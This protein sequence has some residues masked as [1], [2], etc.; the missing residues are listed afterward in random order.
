MACTV[1]DAAILLGALAGA[2]PRDPA[3]RA[4]GRHASKD[5]TRFL[6][7][8][9]LEHARIGVARNMAGPDARIIA[10]LESCLDVMKQL[11]ATII[12]PANVPNH[13]KFAKSELEVL[14]FEFKAD[15][16]RYL[17]S[18]GP[19][20]RV[21]TLQ[22][23][24]RFN[25][26]NRAR[27]MP[28]FGQEH[29][30]TAQE[31]GPLSSRRYREA[32]ARSRRLA[33]R[34]GVDV[35]MRKYRLD[36]IVVPSGAPAWT[37]DLVNGDPLSWDMDIVPPSSVSGYPHITVPAGYIFGLPVGLSFFATA[38]QE[39][40]LLRLAYAFEQ[41]T[42]V[43][44]PPK[45]LASADVGQQSSLLVERSDDSPLASLR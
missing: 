26:E 43:R 35:I 7:Q 12:D 36:A 14:W 11:G 19:M 23:V 15:L 9:G 37:I 21:R 1:Q 31:K 5:Y 20:V 38:W 17:A 27:V 33:R 10:I 40:V 32:L 13:D 34:E 44:R 28:Y 25:E 41:A 24:I 22:D 39:P 8:R 2:D 4:T 45:F 18:R 6:D 3:T 30:I 42:Q 16:N 29:M